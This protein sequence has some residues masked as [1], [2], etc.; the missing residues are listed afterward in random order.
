MSSDCIYTDKKNM[1]GV[2]AR[3]YCHDEST[4]S[5]NVYNSLNEDP[6]C[7][8]P[9]P[10]NAVNFTSFKVKS[11]EC[12]NSGTAYVRVKL[13]KNDFRA[14]EWNPEWDVMFPET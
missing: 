4:Y 7:Q 10:D 14:W 12:V 1:R 2:K 13:A 8:R 11:G 9:Y 6:Y 3:A 5:L